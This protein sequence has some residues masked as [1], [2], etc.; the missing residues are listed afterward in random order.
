MSDSINAS[1]EWLRSLETYERE[2]GIAPYLNPLRPESKEF[3]VVELRTDGKWRIVA[4]GESAA[5][6]IVLAKKKLHHLRDAREN[7]TDAQKEKRIDAFLAGWGGLKES[8]SYARSY[9][10][11]SL[12]DVK[13]A[14]DKYWREVILMQEYA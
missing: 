14:Q 4:K 8:R 10:E 11:A 7:L 12:W 5:E 1:L 6:A 9:L 2:F 3:Q 13:L